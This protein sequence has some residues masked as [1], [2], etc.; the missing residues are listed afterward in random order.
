MILRVVSKN[1][2]VLLSIL[3]LLKIVKETS[4]FLQLIFGPSFSRD[5]WVIDDTE[6]TNK[7]HMPVLVILIVDEN[8]KNQILI[9]IFVG[10]KRK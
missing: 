2:M 10:E 9:F 8:G 1:G 6:C 4:I 3:V 7:Y 5:I